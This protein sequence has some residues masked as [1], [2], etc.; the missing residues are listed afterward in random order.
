MTR[1]SSRHRHERVCW[2]E[3]RWRWRWRPLLSPVALS[4]MML[5]SNISPYGLSS[6]CMAASSE[7][8]VNMLH[9]R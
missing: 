8:L 6:A 2:G 1:H 7:L 4:L 5:I 9:V 3:V